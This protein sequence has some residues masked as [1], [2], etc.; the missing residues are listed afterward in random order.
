MPLSNLV[1]VNTGEGPESKG[2]C[3]EPTQVDSVHVYILEKSTLTTSAYNLS[4]SF[5]F[6]FV[7]NF[8]QVP[9]SRFVYL[10]LCSH[11]PP[12]SKS[13]CLTFAPLS[14]CRQTLRLHTNKQLLIQ[15]LPITGPPFP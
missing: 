5:T 4:T 13:T 6:H 8:F 15:P 14:I 3:I 11:L 12:T 9:M 10:S 1:A 7:A 2:S